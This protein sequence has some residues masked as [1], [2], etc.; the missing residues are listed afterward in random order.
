[1]RKNYVI[2][3]GRGCMDSTIVHVSCTE[4]DIQTV[5][6]AVY[7]YHKDNGTWDRPIMLAYEEGEEFNWDDLGMVVLID[8]M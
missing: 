4:A 8:C 7:Y 6:M 3:V 2:A 1:M 5:A